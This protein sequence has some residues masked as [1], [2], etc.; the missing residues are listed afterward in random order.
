M[1]KVILVGHPGSQHIV[2]ASKYLTNKYLPGFDIRYLN[3][4][5]PKE[6]WS[7]FLAAYFRQLKDDLVIFA[8][9]DYLLSGPI[10]NKMYHQALKEFGD[11]NVVS[12]KLCESTMHEHFEYPVTTQYMLW[13]RIFLINLLDKTKDPW[14]FEMTGS[15]LFRE[16]GRDSILPFSPVLKYDVHSC[17][18]VRWAGINFNGVKKEDLDYIKNNKLII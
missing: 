2:P 6:N 15:S 10:D 7:K 8:L 11:R 14:H 13:N 1:T 12:V 3:H 18:S 9:D 5:G 4:V 16:I 17:L